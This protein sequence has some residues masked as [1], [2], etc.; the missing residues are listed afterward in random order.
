VWVSICIIAEREPSDLR[1]LAS[2]LAKSEPVGPI[3][4]WFDNTGL[5]NPEQGY[6]SLTEGSIA[7]SAFS[8]AFPRHTSSSEADGIVKIAH[9]PDREIPAEE[10]ADSLPFLPAAPPRRR[11]R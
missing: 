7:G 5:K 6:R 2:R 1:P 9:V 10:P 4:R 3:S 11:R 8:A